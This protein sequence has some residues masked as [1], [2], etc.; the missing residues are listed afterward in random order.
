MKLTVAIMIGLALAG[1]DPMPPEVQ[2][3]IIEVPSAKPY[4]F[5]QWSLA[6]TKDTR[7]AIRRHNRAHQAVIEASKAKAAQ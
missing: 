4:S 5:I 2:T 1:C 7:A 6:D 3:R